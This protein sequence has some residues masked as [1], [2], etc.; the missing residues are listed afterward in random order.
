M[1]LVD[2]YKELKADLETI[3]DELHKAIQ[4][5]HSLM[6]ETSAHL[7]KAGG[8]R[9]RPVFVLLGGKQGTYHL[10]KLTH[11]AVALE[12][13]HMATLVHDDVIDDADTRRGIQTVKAKWDNKM[14]MYTG[15]YIL[16]KALQCITQIEDPRL[17]QVLSK[18]IVEMTLGEIEQIKALYQWEQ[19][20]RMY[21]K[22]IKRKTALLMAVS[23]QLGGIACQ[24]SESDLKALFQYG[25]NVGMA[26]QIT[27]DILDFV[28]TEK[29]LGKPAGSDLL[30]GNI[31]LPVLAAIKVPGVLQTIQAEFMEHAVPNMEKIIELVKSN[32]GISY[33]QQLAKKYLDKAR[34]CAQSLSEPKSKETLILIAN[35][36]EHRNF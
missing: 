9:I 16:A 29:Q 13:I 7:L 24:A 32:G 2:I 23:C 36:I 35:F 18:A 10:G 3:E 25:Y 21:L 11:V 28:A 22:R 17:H 27:D 14:A 33:S 19:S 15:D 31:T 34:E 6:E 5:P 26:F 8:K 4:T 20:L 30:Q 12:L 1:N